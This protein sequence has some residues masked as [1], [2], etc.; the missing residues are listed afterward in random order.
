MKRIVK[1][2]L[3]IV[4]MSIGVAILLWCVWSVIFPNEYFHFRLIDIPRLLVPVLFVWVGWRWIRGD[5]T[6][7]TEYKSE[8]TI[9]LR[10][11][12]SEFGAQTERESIF[13]LIHRLETILEEQNLGVVDGEEFGNGECTIFI[14]TNTPEETNTLLNQFLN[15][16]T[17]SFNFS[18]SQKDL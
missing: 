9:T 7:E 6:T 17:P 8:L 11:S 14:Q 2:I 1:I 15:S 5:A 12:D 3:G 10:L 18:V 4:S 16:H 13:D